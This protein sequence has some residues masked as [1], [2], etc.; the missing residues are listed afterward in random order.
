M[1][2]DRARRYEARQLQAVRQQ[3]CLAHVQRSLAEA[4]ADQW[5]RARSIPQ[6]LRA[7]LAAARTLWRQQQ[8]GERTVEQ[9]A[10]QRQ[11]LQAPVSEP[12]RPR[13][14]TNPTNRR[15]LNEV[16]WHHDQ[17]NR[18]R[19]L[20]DPQVEPT[21]NGAERALRPAVVARQVSHCSQKARGAI[22]YAAFVSMVCT[23]RQR[24]AEGLIAAL[25]S[26]FTTGAVRDP[27][28]HPAQVIGGHRQ[29]GPTPV[30]AAACSPLRTP[31]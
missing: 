16:G 19:F 1:V 9:F 3:Q 24:G 8:A 13:R 30:G 4:V 20:E 23:L 27:A 22:A 11:R 26:V 2:C 29:E 10:A 14:L 28:G 12:L 18:L 25:V 15:L 5:G 6:R 31:R 17:G 21:N 7:Q